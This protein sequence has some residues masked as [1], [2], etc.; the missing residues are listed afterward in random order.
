MA[1]LDRVLLVA[2]VPPCT[3][4]S[5]GLFLDR[6]LSASG[7]PAGI[8]AIQ[9]PSLKPHVPS[10]YEER[11]PIKIVAKPNEMYYPPDDEVRRKEQVV[12]DKII[13]SLTSELMAFARDVNAE[14]IWIVLEGQTLIRV[15][16]QLLASSDFLLRVQ[17]MDPPGW[18]LRAHNVDPVSSACVIEQFECVLRAAR[19]CA[20]ASWA[21]G[22]AYRREFG[23]RAVPVVPALDPALALPPAESPQPRSIRIG[24]AGQ[25]YAFD[26]FSTLVRAMA[27]LRWNSWWSTVELHAFADGI[28]P[29][30]GGEEVIVKH[31][32]LPQD[33]LIPALSQLD[34]LYVPYWFSEEFRNEANLCFPSKLT[35]CLATGRP[36][37]FHG[38]ADSSP[39]RF[40]RAGAAAFFC[41]RQESEA[42]HDLIQ[43]AVG[44]HENYKEIARNGRS[45]FDQNLTEPRL[46]ES[47]SEFLFND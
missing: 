17:V 4:Y 21:M 20:A 37:I 22:D 29:V 30:G 38:R 39:G 6:I 24:F 27:K 3:N 33:Q 40:L 41:F 9:N 23:V 7:Y 19:S 28:P 47:F 45:L 25:P 36:V 14:E 43:F 13:P 31:P 34:L 35:T 16:H 32:W 11:V 2:G 44:Q 26:E 12:V 5:G 10:H 42:L 46:H 15:A 18:W 8:F 1:H